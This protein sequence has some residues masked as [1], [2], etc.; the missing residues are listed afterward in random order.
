MSEE[1]LDDLW[2]PVPNGLA[3]IAAAFRVRGYAV[4]IIDALAEGYDVRTWIE[5][6]GRRI[7]RIGLSDD[8]LSERLRQTGT[9][10]V[11]IGNMF[12]ASFSGTSE[13]AEIAR[14][15]FP[16]AKVVLGGVHPSCAPEEAISLAAVDYVICGA[17]EVAFPEL[18]RHL[19]GSGG[20][21]MPPGVYWKESG[22]F[23]K[24]GNPVPIADPD[25]LPL[26]AYDLLDMQFYR[27][28][29]Q[30]DLV[31]RGESGIFTMPIVTSHGCPYKCIFCAAH[32][33]NGRHWRGRS[34][35]RVVD[36]MELLQK[37]Y[38]VTSFT[39]ED[40]NFSYD[41]DRA[42]AICNEIVRRDL[43][44]RWNT[45]NGLRADRITP[46]L[47][48]AMRK[49]GCYEITLAAEHGDQQFLKRVVRKE[50][51][52]EDIFR[53]GKIARKEGLAVTCFLMMGFPGETERELAK[54]V[55]FGHRL[56]LA[57]IFP[58]FFIGA[59][60]PGTAMQAMFIRSGG[61]PEHSLEPDD[62]LSSFRVPMMEMPGGLDLPKWRHRAM[63]QAYLVFLLF[64]PITASRLPALRKLL[65]S[66]AS[67]RTCWPALK[68]LYNQFWLTSQKGV[69]PPL[70]KTGEGGA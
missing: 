27:T 4:S 54:S 35:V 7:C 48:A 25:A 9:G 37:D 23:R 52:L 60:F 8:A 26:A 45:P 39:I 69:V 42:V 32:R 44:L 22:G 50:L 2:L 41:V 65:M 3:L 20:T 15:V 18:V 64:H 59:P 1:N 11:G 24:S 53:A 58:L 66:L 36:E 29:A 63:S 21:G 56:A 46:Q 62:Y 13:C 30:K 68:K 16:A 55:R 33:L 19:E 10:V 17:G 5:R 70:A 40:S 6:N 67:P 31:S 14:R 57:G 28:A 38:G 34:P 61:L 43:R 51:N 47:V 12:T 49:A